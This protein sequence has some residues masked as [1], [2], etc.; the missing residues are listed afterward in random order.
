[1]EDVN[2][3]ALTLPLDGMRVLIV[4]DYADS[5]E[6][7]AVLFAISGAAVLAVASGEEAVEAL[8]LGRFDA[9][10]SDVHMPGISGLDL[11]REIRR[12]SDVDALPA[13]AV[14]A[15]RD[16]ELRGRLLE[17]GFQTY[18][19]KPVLGGELVAAVRDLVRAA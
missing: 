13:V 4:E 18:L 6:M 2:K 8:A 1:M 16:P 7:F 19:T 9:V 14:T 15:D 3:G 10:V 11:I 12:S 17:A 5:R